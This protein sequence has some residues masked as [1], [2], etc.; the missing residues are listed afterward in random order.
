MTPRLPALLT[1]DRSALPRV[2]ST[3]AAL[4]LIALASPAVARPSQPVRIADDLELREIAPGV[5]RYVAW[6]D[7]PKYGRTAANGMIVVSGRDALMV[8]TG[9]TN[10]QA[11][12]LADWVE[13][14]RGARIAIVVPTHS[15]ADTM[16]GLE[17]L[18]RRGATSWAQERTATLARAAGQEVPK[19]T[20]DRAK[21][22]K[23]G[24]RV[25]KL[26]FHGAGHTTDNIVVWLPTER[27]LFGG[28]L[29]KAADSTSLGDV[30]D[31]RISNWPATIQSVLDAYP[32]SQQV[33]P[34]HGNPGGRE[35]LTHTL[36]LARAQQR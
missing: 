5:W 32:D 23:V 18:H 13:R 12:R 17:E 21:E 29:V 28:C 8:N 30:S 20:F 31:A 10:D 26:A 6:L 34:G 7:L 9:W 11:G 33:I 25:V 22:L 14:T 35:L 36:Q 19:Q 4:A 1:R 16:G 27:I 2:R 3:L 15:H 24:A